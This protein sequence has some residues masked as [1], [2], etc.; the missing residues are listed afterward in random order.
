[1][2]F[3]NTVLV[4]CSVILHPVSLSYAQS[5]AINFCYPLSPI[6]PAGSGQIICPVTGDST[7]EGT[8]HYVNRQGFLEFNS[9]FNKYHLGEDW[10]GN[11]GGSTDLYSPIYA[12]ADG[13]V[14]FVDDLASPDGTLHPWGKVVVIRH[15]LLSGEDVYSL[16]GHLADWLVPKICHNSSSLSCMVDQGQQIATLG[17]GNGYYRG[18]AHLHLEIRKQFA[19]F[20]TDIIPGHGYIAD[21]NDPFVDQHYYHPTEFIEQ[22]RGGVCS[23]SSTAGNAALAASC[24]PAPQGPTV[25]TSGA[26]NV[27]QGSATL[28][29]SVDPKTS[30][31]EVWF[32]W[33]TDTNFCC[34][35][36]R[37][38]ISGGVGQTLLGM[39]LGGLQCDT[40]YFFRARAQ[41]NGGSAT[42]NTLSFRTGACG[43][44][45]QTV[46]LVAD[47]GFEGGNN[48][49]WVA[50]PAFFINR[51]PTFPNPR[52]GSFYAFL[53]N[54]NG[55]PGNNLQGGMI[56]PQVTIAST[57][58]SAELRFWRSVSTQE[59]TSS[60]A[61]DKLEAYLVKPGNQLT[62]LTTISNLNHSGTQYLET[63]VPLS[64]SFFGQTVQ[65]FFRGTTDATLPTVFRLDDVTLTVTSPV[66]GPP[67]VT[68]QGADQITPSTARLNMAVNPGGANTTVWFNIEAGD[69]TPDNETEHIAIG[70]GSQSQSVNITSFALQCNTL[71]FYRARAQNVHGSVQGSVQSFTTGACSGGAPRADTD[72][73][74]NVSLTSATLNAEVN[75]NGLPTQAW[76]A[77]GLGTNFSQET[78][79]ISAGSGTGFSNFS[80]V[81]TGLSC[82]TT[83]SFQNKVSNSAGQD[84]GVTLSFTTLPCSSG[85][86]DAVTLE[87]GLDPEEPA[88]A[89]LNSLVNPNGAETHAFFRWGTTPS[90]GNTTT[91]L[92]LGSGAS[93]I[94]FPFILE[95]LLCGTTY[96]Y[97]VVAVNLHGTTEGADRS[98]V[99]PSCG[100]GSPVVSVISIDDSASEANLATGMFRVTRTGDTAASLSLSSSVGGTAIPDSDYENLASLVIPSGSATLDITVLPKQ[101]TS[102]E[103]DETVILTLQ[104]QSHYTVGT[105]SSAT[106][107][108]TSDDVGGGDCFVNIISPAGGEIWPKSTPQTVRWDAGPGCVSFAFRLLRNGLHDGWIDTERVITGTEFIW[109]PAA[110]LVPGSDLQIEVTGFNAAGHGSSAL[111]NSFNLVNSSV[112]PSLI[113]EDSVETD[114]SNWGA[115]GWIITNSTSHSP[116]HSRTD[117]PGS[118]E[119]D[120][121]NSLFPPLIDVSGRQSVYLTFWHRFDLADFDSAN[122][123]VRPEQGDWTHLRFFVGQQLEWKPVAIDL[124]PFIGQSPLQLAFQIVSDESLTADGWYIDDIK[125]HEPLSTAFYTVSP[126]RLVDTR[127][128]AVPL[129]S[130]VLQ[131]FTVSGLCGVPPEARAGSFNITAVGPTA[132][133]HISLFPADQEQPSTSSVNFGPGQTRANNAVL[134][135]SADGRL[136][137]VATLPGGAV[138]LIVDVNGYF[139]DV[140]PMEGLWSGTVAGHAAELTISKSGSTY[141]VLLSMATANEP[142]EQLILLFV[143]P[144][145]LTVHRPSDDAQLRV[146]RTLSGGQ[147]CLTGEYIEDGTSRPISLCK[148]P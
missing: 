25:T 60:M 107:I 134:G 4:L 30:T 15:R 135:L 92:T 37:Q 103:S 78:P 9:D 93:D 68:T 79:R 81:L 126:C 106:V 38:S 75:P 74:T 98:F 109:S 49:W 54:T 80:Q 123:W 20:N 86:P 89:I 112:L 19:F 70:G 69:S 44:T 85:A 22:H 35:T 26:S 143:S 113:L 145:Q 52:N 129:L 5:F 41:N 137:A 13:V 40:T 144:T 17:D 1:M 6:G 10:N 51:A 11:G 76:F 127:G 8:T 99:T 115:Q 108:I 118:Y 18:L 128:G 131:T 91:D 90:Y 39:A 71:Y 55:S 120:A 61:F 111:S 83:Y 21:P 121:N 33:D 32:D 116:R 100:Q 36:Q 105:P 57:A 141:T 132:G 136:S 146:T 31:T 125:I 77:W 84:S 72:A 138:D 97:R 46:Q 139:A 58:T 114:M 16:Y 24:E 87:A 122:V 133:G 82:G 43:S 2:I 142:I 53:S 47:P 73:A 48:A 110:W 14:M 148:A 101:D 64:S 56:S 67:S 3:R 117:S 29:L 27:T 45:S 130:G 59:T 94:L 102:V 65:I 124:G 96:H 42:G 7:L 34:S 23:P 50:D 66:G 28:N 95:G 63:R 147:Q 12:V 104:P 119:N 88:R 140:D 62:L